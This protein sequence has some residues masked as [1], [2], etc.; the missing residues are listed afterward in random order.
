VTH[1]TPGELQDWL[2]WA[3]ARLLAMPARKVKPSE[4]KVAWP[5]YS[6]D[7]FEILDFR[8]GISFRAAAPSKDEIP[9]VEEILTLPAFCREH[10]VRRVLHI[11][12]LI[13]PINGRYMYNWMKVA[14][15]LETNRATAKSWHAKGLVEVIANAPREKIC[16][17]GHS[18]RELA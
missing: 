8:A 3:G 18:L 11:R 7:K 4:P 13:H 5:T 2:E 12:A 6:Q 15:M 10:K 16:L 17:I 9:V 1:I 14:K